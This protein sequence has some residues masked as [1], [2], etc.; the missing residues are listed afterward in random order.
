MRQEVRKLAR[1]VKGASAAP[2]DDG[3]SAIQ[4]AIDL[5]DK[6]LAELPQAYLFRPKRDHYEQVIRRWRNQLVKQAHEAITVLDM[7]DQFNRHVYR[8]SADILM[9]NLVNLSMQVAPISYVEKVGNDEWQQTWQQ[10]LEGPLRLLLHRR[11]RGHP[12]VQQVFETGERLVESTHLAGALLTVARDYVGK[13]GELGRRPPTARVVSMGEIK[14]SMEEAAR[15]MGIRGDETWTI[16][17]GLRDRK[18]PGSP[19]IWELIAQE[20]ATN[21]AKYSQIDLSA[22]QKPERVLMRADVQEDHEGRLYVL[23]AANV[24]YLWTVGDKERKR[25]ERDLASAQAV[26]EIEQNLQSFLHARERGHDD[27]RGAGM[28]LYMIDKI[29][30]MCDIQTQLLLFNPDEKVSG[31]AGEITPQEKL[32]YPLCLCLSWKEENGRG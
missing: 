16:G 1:L 26:E 7:L 19:A 11:L 8:T 12:L 24:P 4:A 20:F 10:A 17:A 15:R 27:D 30:E 3:R 31:A 6:T 2:V 5:C 18:A 23:I 14:K 13:P 9:D 29:T 32:G 28:G 25:Y 21:I 22:S